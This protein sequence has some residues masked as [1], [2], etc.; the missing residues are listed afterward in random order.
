MTSGRTPAPR[1]SA[2]PKGTWPSSPVSG[3]VSGHPG[4]AHRRR[5]FAPNPFPIARGARPASTMP[6]RLQMETPL[7]L[8]VAAGGALMADAHVGYG[9]P[10]GGVLAVREAVIPWAVGLDIAC[11]LRLSV[12]ELSSHMLGQQKNELE[13]A[14]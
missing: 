9:L 13:R 5:S 1:W 10:I 7:R 4:P 14:L 12:F 8:P 6:P 11:R 2:S 3:C